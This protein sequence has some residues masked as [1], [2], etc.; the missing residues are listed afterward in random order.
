MYLNVVSLLL[1]VVVEHISF[2]GFWYE[3][4]RFETYFSF[5]G[6][7]SLSHWC[8]VILKNKLAN[9]ITK[10][11]GGGAKLEPKLEP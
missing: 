5:S 7:V 11:R 3:K 1:A 2:G 4:N 10:L 9:P 8:S 6:K